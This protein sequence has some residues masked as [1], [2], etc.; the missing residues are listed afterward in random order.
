MPEG[1]THVPPQKGINGPPFIVIRTLGIEKFHNLVAEYAIIEGAVFDVPNLSRRQREL[2][3]HTCICDNFGGDPRHV[4]A[5]CIA[6][7]RDY[8]LPRR[9]QGV[10]W[11]NK[12]DTA[13]L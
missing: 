6:S 2:S 7:R 4:M 11:A 10:L 5:T 8:H 1:V 13:A 12:N 9:I 3:L